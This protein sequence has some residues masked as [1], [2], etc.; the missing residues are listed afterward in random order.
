MSVRIK[1]EN[2]IKIY[3]DHPKDA[4]RMLKEGATREDV[5]KKTGLTVGVY[6]ASFEVNEGEIFVLIGLSGSGKSSLLRCIN[7]LNKITSG[8]LYVDEHPVHEINEA[9][10]RALQ[11]S[12]MSMV[13]QH[14]AILPNRTI[15]ENVA[16]GMEIRGITKEERFQ[17]SEEALN[18]VGLRDWADHLPDELS[19]GMKQRVGLARAL[20]MNSDILLMDEPFSALDAL[21]RGE[22]Q[23]ELVSLQ[24]EIKKTIVFVTHD[25][26]E[27][28]R[29]GDKIAIMK[30]GVIE[31][32]G[33]AEEI[34][35]SPANDYVSRF[36]QSV[37]VSKILLAENLARRP[38]EILKET[39]GV[40]IASRK[41]EKSDKDYLFVIDS[42]K[43]L[44]GIVLMDDILQLREKGARDISPAIM[45]A[46]FVESSEVM[47][48]V[49]PILKS[50]EK[51]LAVVDAE[52]RFLG[53]I[54]RRSLITNLA[55]RKGVA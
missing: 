1:A 28:L 15:R 25:L 51:S 8:S 46:L 27:A 45:K 37:D 43:K 47:Q 49:Y 14:F 38:Q 31:Q 17:R 39:E 41:L 34:L 16:F 33:S 36:L 26:D 42:Q 48:N 29:L 19:G 6:N 11:G 55:E 7:G 2:L 4:L 20:V 44:K 23:E 30:D 53:E 40:M 50:T 35:A 21:I 10:L 3:G 32:I 5:L 12:K 22:M 18:K 13:F 54:T 52:G 9:K 24:Q